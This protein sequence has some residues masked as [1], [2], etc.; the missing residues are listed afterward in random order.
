MKKGALVDYNHGLQQEK[1][2]KTNKMTCVSS[3]D[4][5]QP[6]NLPSLISLRFQH[7]KTMGPYLPSDNTS[8]TLMISLVRAEVLWLSQQLRSCRAGQLPIYTVLGQA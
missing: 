1:D 3:K 5:D 6:G 7:D 8:K 2:D 4:S